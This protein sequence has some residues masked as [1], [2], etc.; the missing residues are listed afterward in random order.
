M[1]AITWRQA[2]AGVALQTGE[3]EV[4]QMS[5]RA[6]NR[7][8]VMLAPLSLSLVLAIA[9]FSQYLYVDAFYKALLSWC[10]C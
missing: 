6:S 4:A 3:K 8:S 5:S 9:A 2:T 7:E 1:P 10:L